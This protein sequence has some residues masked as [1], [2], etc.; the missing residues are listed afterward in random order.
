MKSLI[1]EECLWT[2]S[3]L[4]SLNQ[5]KMSHDC[6]ILN[7][8]IGTEG[9]GYMVDILRWTIFSI[10]TLFTG[11]IAGFGFA[12]RRVVIVWYHLAGIV[13]LTLMFSISSS[14]L[15][16]MLK[17]SFSIRFLEIVIGLGIIVIGVLL[18][19]SKPSYPGNKDIFLFILAIQIDVFL[20]SFH[21]GF[22]HEKGYGLAFTISLLMLGSIVSGMAFGGKRWT[23]W[24]IQ[25]LLPHI[26]GMFFII[27]GLIKML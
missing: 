19:V 18:I 17:N 9:G 26:S 14:F 23:N 16:H 2:E 11:T 27:V 1:L 21:Y 10:F 4:C 22:S 7:I 12:T 13:I 15:G 25:M 3:T 8:E 5:F 6:G 20:L 24:R